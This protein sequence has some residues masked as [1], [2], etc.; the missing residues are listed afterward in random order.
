MMMTWCMIGGG[1]RLSSPPPSS[2]SASSSASSS[3]LP[4]RLLISSL[5]FHRLHKPSSPLPLPLPLPRPYSSVG[6]LCEPTGVVVSS[7]TISAAARPLCSSL[8]NQDTKT[9]KEEEE[10]GDDDDG[11]NE[12]DDDEEEVR[13]EE[14][15]EEEK[16]FKGS[17][18][19]GNRRFPPLTPRE[20]KEL[21]AYA[22][23]LGKKIVSQQVNSPLLFLLILVVFRLCFLS[24]L[25]LPIMGC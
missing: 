18:H 22:H 19:G 16:S 17:I 25:V 4:W 7:N 10:E 6:R 15:E 20:K 14:I 8:G 24:L 12:Y 11:Y 9:E 13:D 3:F 2:S 1:L 23:S 21:R 5:S